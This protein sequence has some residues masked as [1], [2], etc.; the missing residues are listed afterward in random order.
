MPKRRATL[1]ER[2]GSLTAAK[3]ARGITLV[4]EDPLHSV[5]L[6][7]GAADSIRALALA[8]GVVRPWMLKLFRSRRYRAGVERSVAWFGSG[9]LLRLTLRKRY[10]DDELRA[11]VSRGAE[12]VLILGPGFDTVGPRLARDFPELLVV[13]V[14]TPATASRR[15]QGLKAT[16]GVPE[17]LHILGRDLDREPLG[18]LLHDRGWNPDSR[19]AAVAEGVLMYLTPGEVRGLL[20]TL[21]GHG[22]AGGTLVFTYMKVDERGRPFVGH[23]SSFSRL[24]LRL[25]GEPLQWGVPPDGLQRFL[26][27]EGFRLVDAPDPGE[28]ARRY[29][30]PME[31]G[32]RVVGGVE[33]FAVAEWGRT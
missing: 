12:Q 8:C 17:N 6:P 23:A 28:L 13:E 10:V 21:K 29:L 7:A 19:S 26:G 32:D 33:R 16:F 4:A 25:M 2:R 3:I 27:P 9:E 31:A 24:T 1:A 11:A 5:L 15:A 22:D 14:D 18:G 30:A 20:R